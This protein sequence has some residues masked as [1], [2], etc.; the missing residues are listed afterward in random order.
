M[1]L[2]KKLTGKNPSEY[3][4]VAKA[5]VDNADVDLFFKLVGQDNF[6]FDF[7]KENVALRIQRACNKDNYL[8]LLKFLSVYSHS[9]DTMIVEVLHTFGGDSL[10]GKMRELFRDGNNPQK[11][12]ALKYFS[13]VS[14]DI[15]KT[16]IP[17]IR[18][19][20]KSEYEPIVSNAIELLSDLHDDVSKNEEF[21][22]LDSQDEFEQYDAVKFLVSY[23]AKDCLSKILEVMKKSSFSENIASE[24]PYLIPLNELL[25]T[26]Y[27]NALLVLAHII[28]AIP[29]IIPPSAVF[30]YEIKRVIEKL[31]SMPI[32]SAAAL[33]LR[34]ACDKFGELAYN[35]EYLFDSDKKT[36]EEIKEINNILSSLE[37]SQLE[38]YLYDELYEDS[39]FVFFALDYVDELAELET[40]LESKNQTLVLKTLTIIKEKGFLKDAHKE[41]ALKNV[42]NPDIRNIVTVL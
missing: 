10:F 19:A 4:P 27:E 26:D 40:L 12:Y 16:L 24:I 23:G 30:S 6:L 32:E 14:P 28:N 21:A 7:I 42:T 2:I 5:L 22:K 41:I 11:A 37:V 34:M 25:E 38:S 35:E 8:N 17:Q 39:D 33:V 3:E 31:I 20:V 15:V 1:D 13:L 36:K 9:Y 29:E 18:E